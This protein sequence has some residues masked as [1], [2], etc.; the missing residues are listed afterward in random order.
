[1][2]TSVFSNL[3][4]RIQLVVLAILLT[5]PA[6]GI[7]VYT[8]LKEHNDDYRKAAIESQKLADHLAAEMENLAHEAQ[9]LGGFLAELPDVANRN[10]DKI[11]SIIR[12]T[13]KKNPQFKNIIHN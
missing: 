2:H 8:G 12:N 5:L 9:Q 7:I 13:L 1:M 6:L 4:I 10:T 3:P 11:Q